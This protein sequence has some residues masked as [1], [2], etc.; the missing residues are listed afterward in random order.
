MGEEMK[1]TD[2]DSEVLHICNGNQDIANDLTRQYIKLFGNR[3]DG[4]SNIQHDVTDL[5]QPTPFKVVQT[6]TTY[7]VPISKDTV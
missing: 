4:R 2:N 3:S 1:R 6:Y 7:G 5:S